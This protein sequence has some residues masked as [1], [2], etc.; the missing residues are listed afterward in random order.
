VVQWLDDIGEV[1]SRVD[2]GV[3]GMVDGLAPAAKMAALPGRVST[4]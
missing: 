1:D 3:D 2:S 4:G